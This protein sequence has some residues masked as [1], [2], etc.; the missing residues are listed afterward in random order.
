MTV[1]FYEREREREREKEKIRIEE[2]IIRFIYH[3]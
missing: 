2:D 3:Y 1:L